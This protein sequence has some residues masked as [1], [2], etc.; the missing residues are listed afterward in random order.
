MTTVDVRSSASRAEM[1]LT[2]FMLILVVLGGLVFF[3]EPVSA[4]NG[5][6]KDVSGYVYEGDSSHPVE[7]AT[8]VLE[9]WDGTDLRSTCDPV[10]T[11]EDGFYFVVIGSLYGEYWEA[12]D[13]L[14]VTATYGAS[15]KSES[16]IAD[17]GPAQVVPDIVFPYAIP[18]L[19]GVAGTMIAVVAVGAI[20]VVFLRKNRL[21]RGSA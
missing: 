13:I 6:P 5:D 8:I 14:K 20:A 7:G 12:G 4:A 17:T 21:N 18:Q 19:A 10:E 16:I 3:S 15:Q 9:I 11:D 2:A 1:S